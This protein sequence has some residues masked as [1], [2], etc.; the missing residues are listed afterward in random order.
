[1]PN[2][3]NA[4]P[5]QAHC[6][7]PVQTITKSLFLLLKPITEGKQ[8][9]YRRSTRLEN[10]GALG[11]VTSSKSL[12]QWA[13][14]AVGPARMTGYMEVM[15]LVETAPGPPVRPRTRPPPVRDLHTPNRPTRC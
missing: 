13:S 11:V 3:A 12:R 4:S 9:M 10:C 2:H 15:H 8:L 5:E 7:A 6:G 14:R 1:M